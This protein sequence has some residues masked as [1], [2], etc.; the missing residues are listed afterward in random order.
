MQFLNK[1]NEKTIKKA[2]TILRIEQKCLGFVFFLL[3]RTLCMCVANGMVQKAWKCGYF[4]YFHTKN[5]KPNNV[6]CYLS[7]CFRSSIQSVKSAIVLSTSH[8]NNFSIY[9]TNAAKWNFDFFPLSSDR[10]WVDIGIV[11]LLLLWRP[12]ILA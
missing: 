3:L 4:F 5:A 2:T 1:H 6:V 9:Q 12:V 7:V 11:M 8:M 10:E